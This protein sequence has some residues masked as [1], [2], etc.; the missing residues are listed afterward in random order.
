MIVYL[1]WLV[2]MGLLIALGEGDTL[3]FLEFGN[4]WGVA[5]THAIIHGCILLFLAAATG[6]PGYFFHPRRLPVEVQNRGIALSYYMCGVLS[7]LLP[8]YVL[9]FIAALLTRQFSLNEPL[10]VGTIVVGGIGF[11]ALL[12]WLILECSFGN[13]ILGPI[14]AWTI[15]WL[16]IP[17][18]IALA[19]GIL[20]VIPTMIFCMALMISSIT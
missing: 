7:W 15:R 6:V 3:D 20:V 16:L 5:A 13:R 11:L 1:P 17:L 12:R 10:F 4:A 18:W 14:R 8:A 9:L 2:L 19:L